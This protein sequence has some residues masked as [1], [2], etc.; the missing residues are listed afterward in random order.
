MET[1]NY[2]NPYNSLSEVHPI[3]ITKNLK[4]DKDNQQ[5]ESAAKYY[6]I[7]SLNL[8][9]DILFK[10]AW[11]N[12]ELARSLSD[13]FYLDFLTQKLLRD[14]Y[15]IIENLD[16]IS[17]EDFESVIKEKEKIK[18]IITLKQSTSKPSLLK[19]NK[20]H[21][22][23]NTQTII[24]V[25]NSDPRFLTGLKK[26][27]Y[28]ISNDMNIIISDLKRSIIIYIA[29]NNLQR[30]TNFICDSVLTSLLYLK[31]D[32]QESYY[33]L[34]KILIDSLKDGDTSILRELNH[35]A[36]YT[37]NSKDLSGEVS[38][39]APTFICN[40]NNNNRIPIKKIMPIKK[41]VHSLL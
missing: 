27:S 34:R 30:G 41:K 19:K 16:S 40:S 5:N 3:Y 22:R 28:K 33:N 12:I 7:L 24:S 37:C 35:T 25:K 38:D 31:E 39:L 10:K 26:V 2:E 6:W 11:E 9:R 1:E 15:K 4:N 17:C 20:M 13:T 23:E 8:S 32:S 29:K 14:G 36:S 21:K 18:P